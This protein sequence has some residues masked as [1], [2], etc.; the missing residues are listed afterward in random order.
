MIRANTLQ[1]K[2]VGVITATISNGAIADLTSLTN[3]SSNSSYTITITDSGTQNAA[4]IIAINSKNTSGTI[5]AENIATIQGSAANV[6][7]AY[8]AVDSGLGN[9]NISINDGSPTLAQAISLNALTSGNVTA[10]LADT[11]V[12]DLFRFL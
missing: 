5:A 1:G 3:T 2:T 8:A 4:D 12:S 7:S 9:E 10:T 6:I 11:R